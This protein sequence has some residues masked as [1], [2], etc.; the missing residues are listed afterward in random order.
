MKASFFMMGS[1]AILCILSGQLATNFR[2]RLLG[3]DRY[4]PMVL[5]LLRMCACG[6]SQNCKCLEYFGRMDGTTDAV[7]CVNSSGPWWTHFL[8]SES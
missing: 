7:D 2:P 5:L 4:I 6:G 8:R 1:F 3:F